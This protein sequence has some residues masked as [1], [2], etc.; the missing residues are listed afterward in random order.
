MAAKAKKKEKEPTA[1]AQKMA[2][3]MALKVR[4]A[5]ALAK[6]N[7]A[8][9]AK[10][11]AAKQME[12]PTAKA[13]KMELKALMAKAV[14]EVDTALVA[15]TMA[16]MEENRGLERQKKGDANS[17]ADQEDSTRDYV[18]HAGKCQQSTKVCH[19]RRRAAAREVRCQG[20]MRADVPDFVCMEDG[21]R[22]QQREAGRPGQLPLL[23]SR[24]GRRKTL[25]TDSR[26]STK[27]G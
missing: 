9:A 15:E 24:G 25:G 26:A 3:K 1:T 2:L 11:K 12:E 21:P 23:V 4:M 7:T 16:I 18:S 22:R 27:T 19:T 13:Q 6:A 17:V 14:A 8:L 10:V 20:P 5:K